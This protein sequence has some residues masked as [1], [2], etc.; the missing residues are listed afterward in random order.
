M[1]PVAR[2][3]CEHTGAG[4]ISLGGGSLSLYLLDRVVGVMFVGWL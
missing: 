4:P 1:T 3:S 2:V